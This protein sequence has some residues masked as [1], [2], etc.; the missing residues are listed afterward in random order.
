M[1]WSPQWTRSHILEYT[2]QFAS[3]TITVHAGLAMA[4]ECMQQFCPLNAHNAPLS[5]STL[6]RRPKCVKSDSSRLMIMLT[7]R[8]QYIGKVIDSII[9]LKYLSLQAARRQVTFS[10]YSVDL[11]GNRF[12]SRLC[13]RWQ[14]GVNRWHRS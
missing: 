7:T 13:Q 5:V 3:S 14:R 2:N 8:A 9:L 12:V 4:L 1:K 6:E 10:D 11:L